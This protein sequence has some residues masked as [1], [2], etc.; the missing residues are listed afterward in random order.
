MLATS[1]VIEVVAERAEHYGVEHLV[2]D[3]VMVSRSGDPLLHPSARDALIQRLIPR[4]YV[5]TPNHHEAQAITGLT[6]R[7][8][9]DMH[10]AAVQLHQMGARYV[11]VKGGDVPETSEAVDVLY[12][13]QSHIDLHASRIDTRSTHGTGCTFASA[14]AAELAKGHSVE[15]SVRNAKAYINAAIQAAA[16]LQVGSGYGPLNHSLGQTVI[17]S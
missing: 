13:G 15:G 17:L 6:I 9:Q 3:P 1:D 11:V 12:D 2:V 7:T 16:M 8:V 14:I 5:L 4:A 10:A